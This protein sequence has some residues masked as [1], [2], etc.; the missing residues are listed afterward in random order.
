M[1]RTYGI[2]VELEGIINSSI[3]LEYWNIKEDHSLRNFCNKE[4]V[5]SRGAEFVFKDGMN[6]VESIKALEELDIILKKL[7]EQVSPTYR[8]SVHVHVGIK[9]KKDQLD[10]IKKY[11]YIEPVLYKIA[12]FSRYYSNFCVPLVLYLPFIRTHSPE[13]YYN[14][15]YN[16]PMGRYL[17]VN[18]LSY[19]KFR[20]IEFRQLRATKNINIIKSWLKI[21]K[22][23]VEYNLPENYTTQNIYE[24]IDFIFEKKYK[25]LIDYKHVNYIF[26]V[27]KSNAEIM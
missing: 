26:N 22:S 4:S 9:S 15:I 6:Y 3:S 5:I 27:M 23:L 20:T 25:H 21:I 12:G 1:E 10:I 17:G 19:D 18:V 7:G 16:M 24:M 14:F 2:E 11:L 8:G 13:L